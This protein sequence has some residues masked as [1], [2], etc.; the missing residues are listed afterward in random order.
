[1]DVDVRELQNNTAWIVG[2]IEH[3]ERVTLTA[4]GDPVADIVPRARRPRWLSGEQLRSQLTER[5]ADPGLDRDIED[6]AG[7]PLDGR[8]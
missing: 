5:A 2:A 1:M 8:G 3:G 6:L 7:Q 4:R